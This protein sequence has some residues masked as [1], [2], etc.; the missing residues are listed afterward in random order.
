MITLE[1]TNYEILKE[2]NKDYN[3]IKERLF[4]WIRKE[5]KLVKR[6]PGRL[7]DPKT[8]LVIIKDIKRFG[9]LETGNSYKAYV[10]VGFT[11]NNE[12]R[13]K[14]TI[15]LIYNEGAFLF[16]NNEGVVLYFTKNFFERYKSLKKLY[17][18]SINTIIDTFMGGED[19]FISMFAYETKNKD[20]NADVT[21][22]NNLFGIGL[23]KDNKIIVKTIV[24]QSDLDSWK[25]AYKVTDDED[26]SPVELYCLHKERNSVFQGIVNNTANK[27]KKKEIDELWEMYDKRFKNNK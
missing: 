20:Y 15:Y 9:N 11:K 2:Y 3:V 8:G 13:F 5:H 26:L 25:I 6:A 16:P 14:A 10:K 4:T 27:N 24:E 1:K 7:K 19:E 22:S 23:Y 21:L 12:P 18:V 17:T